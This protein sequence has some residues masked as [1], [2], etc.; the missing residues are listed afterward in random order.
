MSEATET[1]VMPEGDEGEGPKEMS[2]E[3]ILQALFGADEVA[4]RGDLLFFKIGDAE[5]EIC[6]AYSDEPLVVRYLRDGQDESTEM[7]FEEEPEE[8]EVDDLS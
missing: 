1:D 4:I 7:V 5:I 3:E 8:T 2:A 6:P